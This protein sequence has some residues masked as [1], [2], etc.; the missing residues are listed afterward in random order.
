MYHVLATA[1]SAGA[2]AMNETESLCLYRAGEV[3]YKQVNTYE[4]VHGSKVLLRRQRNG[5]RW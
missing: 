1:L 4:R 5:V 2:A 3:G